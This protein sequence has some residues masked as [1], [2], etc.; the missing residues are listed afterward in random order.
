MHDISLS[1]HDTRNNEGLCMEDEPVE[2]GPFIVLS[3]VGYLKVA[4]PMS[5]YPTKL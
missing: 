4:G 1:S 5:V 2:K 3:I